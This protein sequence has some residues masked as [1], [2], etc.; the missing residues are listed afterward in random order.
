MKTKYFND[1]IIGNKEIVAS[2]SKRGELLRFY[3]PMRDHKQYIDF[4]ETGVKINDSN[5]IYL[6]EDVNNIY[7]QKY[8]EDTNIVTTEMRNTYFNLKIVQTD[9]A[10]IK[11]NVMVRRY[12]FTNDNTIALD[13]KFLI[14]SKLHSGE[15]TEVSARIEDNGLVQYTHEDAFCIYSNKTGIASHQLND[16]DR[17]IRTGE[18]R[19][20][21]YIGMSA[22]SSICYEI[23][24]INPGEK[25]Y[26]DIF[27]TVVPNKESEIAN[28]LKEIKKIDALKEQTLAQTYWEKYVKKYNTIKLPEAKNSYEEKLHLIYKRSILLFPLLINQ[29]TGGMIAS[30]EIDEERSQCG[31]YCYCWTRDAIFMTEALDV[32]GMHKETEKFYKNFCKITQSADG[33]WEQRFYTDGTL[34]P[35]WG[36]QIDETASV[37]YGVYRHYAVTGEKKFLKDALK[38]CEKATKFLKKYV[39]DI[40]EDTHK[41]QVSYDLWEMHEGISLYSLA[42]IFGAFEAMKLIYD[43]IYEEFESNRIKQENIRN[44]KKEIEAKQINLKKYVLEHFYDEE[45]KSYVRNLEDRKMDISMIGAVM[46]FGMFTPKEKNVLNTIEK[47]ELTLRTYTGGYKRFEEDNYRGGDPW[48][49]TTMW[50][51]L[52]HLEKG[53]KK[54]AK[55]ELEYIIKT[56]SANGLLSEQINNETMSPSWVIGLG[57]AHAM[58]ILLLKKMI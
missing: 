23:G 58:Y 10:C 50:M 12:V 9:F 4:F 44:D 56:A 15:N 48:S 32:L 26:L 35:C 41:M 51:A 36:Y 17:N 1:A 49:I 6:Q 2:I 39:D 46:P 7:R 47:M 38:M 42:S 13:V 24:R 22:D 30:L 43:E 19:D 3:Y 55:E 57:W 5:L 31:K 27:I 21:D 16:S 53:E 29:E 54:K 40:L 8:V 14:H 45:K 33:M 37:V 52:Y 18:I 25:K 11:N 28:K 20:K 34:A